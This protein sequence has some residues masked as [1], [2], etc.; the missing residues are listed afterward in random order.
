V[1]WYII[2]HADKEPGDFYNPVLR[3]Q[4]Q[5]ISAKGR[6][7][8]EKL[9]AYFTDKPVAKIYVSEYQRTAQTIAYVAQNM[10]LSPILDSRLN[11]IDNGRYSCLSQ[12]GFPS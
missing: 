8:A 4:D 6:A 1:K 2:R 11:E 3:H 5:P 7:Q 12:V 9:S 10:K